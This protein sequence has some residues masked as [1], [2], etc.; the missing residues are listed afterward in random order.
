MALW[1]FRTNF[2]AAQVHD[3]VLDQARRAAALTGRPVEVEGGVDDPGVEHTPV[4]LDR[5]A[6]FVQAVR[7]AG[8]VG[9]SHYDYGTTSSAFWPTLAG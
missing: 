7:D 8:A 5:V 2:T 6:A 9:G 3:W 4:T 1:S